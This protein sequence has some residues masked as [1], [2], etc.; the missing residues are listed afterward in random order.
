MF[1]QWL[2]Q[3]ICI[4][5]GSLI[6]VALPHF[7]VCTN[8]HIG[9]TFCH[10]YHGNWHLCWG[11]IGRL[12][13]HTYCNDLSG[14]VCESLGEKEQRWWAA[15]WGGVGS[16]TLVRGTL[17]MILIDLRERYEG[18][19][20]RHYVLWGPC[21]WSHKVEE[22]SKTTPQYRGRQTDGCSSG[23]ASTQKGGQRLHPTRNHT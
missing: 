8:R 12:Y 23:Q 16:D 3:W 6:F 13:T 14:F 17:W 11:T 18:C 19:R 1:I 2:I 20:H 10:G 9:G 15:T 5:H 7:P 22:C 4:K 21:S